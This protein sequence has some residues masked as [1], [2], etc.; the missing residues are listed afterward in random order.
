MSWRAMAVIG[1]VT[2]AAAAW[3]VRRQARQDARENAR[4][5]EAT[6]TVAPTSATATTSS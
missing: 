3:V 5:A 4:W 6:D 2:G 1:A